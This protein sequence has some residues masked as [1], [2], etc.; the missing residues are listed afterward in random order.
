MYVSRQVNFL[1]K[2]GL[3]RVLIA[4]G[5]G[6][7]WC[8]SRNKDRQKKP[9]MTQKSRKEL[10]SNVTKYGKEWN[11]FRVSNHLKQ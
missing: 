5:P 7:G 2:G 9:Q 1:P 6:W 11:K 4:V 3:P 8:K 10:R